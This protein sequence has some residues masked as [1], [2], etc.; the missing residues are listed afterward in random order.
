MTLLSH[1]V[2]DPTA[3]M[4]IAILSRAHNIDDMQDASDATTLLA[5]RQVMRGKAPAW[6]DA[7]HIGYR[8]ET[9]IGDYPNVERFNTP[10]EIMLLGADDCDGHAPWLAGSLQAHGIKARAVVIESP[11]VGYHVVVELE[12]GRIIDP[13]ARRGML[14]PQVQGESRKLRAFKLARKWQDKAALLKRAAAKTYG[15]K[16]KVLLLLASYAKREAERAARGEKLASD[17]R[18]DDE[19]E[20]DEP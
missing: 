14:D 2:G 1:R 17:R 3:R 18:N 5:R 9:R 12:D 13:S 7:P 4:G 11:G 8:A 10:E 16:A 19:D 6:W 20:D 15:T